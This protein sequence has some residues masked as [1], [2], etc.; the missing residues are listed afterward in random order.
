MRSTVSVTNLAPIFINLSCTMPTLSVSRIGN[1][2]CRIIFPVSISCFRKK[3]VTPVSR[4]P[5]ITAQ[6]IGAAP[7]YWGKSDA[8][9]LKVPSGGMAHTTSGS[10]RKATTICRSA[11]SLRSSS[12][13]ASSLS[14]S[15]CSTGRPIDTAYFFT[16][17]CCS[18][19]PCRPIGLSG[20][21]MTP[22]TL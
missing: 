22:T 5:L 12:M 16:S 20:I 13:N 3:V 18:T 15:G 21:V 19:L 10:I 14:R 17:L 8:C 9:R 2:S 11:L 4:S 1:R 6:L 7:R